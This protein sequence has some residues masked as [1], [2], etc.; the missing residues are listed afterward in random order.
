MATRVSKAKQ[1]REKLRKLAL[2]LPEASEDFPWGERV[3]KVH[4]KIFAFLGRD[5]DPHFGLG[6]KLKASHAQALAQPFASPMRYGLGKSGWISARFEAGATPPFVM[7]KAWLLESY[8]AVAPK[9]L[10]ERA[11][12]SSFVDRRDGVYRQR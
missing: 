4:K 11:V 8:C 6:L 10:A 12:P 7:L 3:V 9:G 1:V 5:M 2:D